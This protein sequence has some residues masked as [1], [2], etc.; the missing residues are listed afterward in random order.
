MS[1]KQVSY[2]FRLGS[3]VWD[4]MGWEKAKA[5]LKATHFT[6]KKA[7]IKSC[8]SPALLF[9][10]LLSYATHIPIWQT[11]P[12]PSQ[13]FLLYPNIHTLLKIDLTYSKYMSPLRPFLP[14]LLFRGWFRSSLDSIPVWG[15]PE[16]DSRSDDLSH[17]LL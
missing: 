1:K 16:T 3:I 17:V 12:N 6:K 9:L 8:Q 2:I 14:D 13:L 5:V 7:E 15:S 4:G 10:S 11:P